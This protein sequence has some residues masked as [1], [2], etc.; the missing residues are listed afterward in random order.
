[1]LS[2]PLTTRASLANLWRSACLWTF[3]GLKYVPSA[4]GKAAGESTWIEEQGMDVYVDLGYTHRLYAVGTYV[5]IVAV[6]G[7][8]SSVSP[9]NYYEFIVSRAP[10]DSLS[11]S[12][13]P[14]LSLSPPPSPSP[15]HTHRLRDIS[16]TSRRNLGEAPSSRGPH[17][18]SQ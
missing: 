6:F 1:M 10:S 16:A 5:S 12:P 13:S 17:R 7:G 2:P 11:P 9:Q 8:V 15:S 18:C 14:S 4:A 3:T